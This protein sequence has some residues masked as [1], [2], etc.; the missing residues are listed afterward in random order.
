MSGAWHQ[1]PSRGGS[2]AGLGFACHHSGPAC[3]H[4]A[5]G[6]IAMYRD[7]AQTGLVTSMAGL[8]TSQPDPPR[9][10]GPPTRN[11]VAATATGTGFCHRRL[12]GL[13]GRSLPV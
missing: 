7:K 6:Q 9:T 11:A 5:Y 3:H 4:L 2:A 1:V 12:M 10:T 13:L 8:V